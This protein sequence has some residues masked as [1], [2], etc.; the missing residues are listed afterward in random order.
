MGAF[1]SV[2]A[3]GL[4][5]LA[6][7]D[8]GRCKPLPPKA[9]VKVNVKPETPVADM[10]TWYSALT[11]QALVVSSDVPVAGKKV[12]ILAPRPITRRELDELFLGALESVGLTIDRDGPFLHII[13]TSK[14]RH[15]NT[16]VEVR[17]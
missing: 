4:L 1:M 14:A 8:P 12:T 10:I 5:V 3:A 15:S 11:C 17:R 7:A 9:K 13:E 16:P 6:S 2:A